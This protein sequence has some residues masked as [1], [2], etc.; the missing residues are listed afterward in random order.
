MKKLFY[1]LALLFIASCSDDVIDNPGLN[2]ESK[3][4]IASSHK[5]SEQ[6]AI[7]TIMAHFASLQND[8]RS[9]GESVSIPTVQDVEVMRSRDF[10]IDSI[11][12]QDLYDTVDTMYQNFEANDKVYLD[13][14]FYI[15]NFKDKK[16][17]AVLAADDRTNPIYAIV[18]EGNYY[19]NS[20]STEQNEG[21]LYFFDNSINTAL[22]DVSKSLKF[23]GVHRYSWQTIPDDMDCD[24]MGYSVDSV[25]RF[26]PV[27]VTRWG[28][29]Y[30]YNKYCNNCATGCVITATAQILSH[31]QTIEHVSW[32]KNNQHGESD[33]NWSRIL[34]DV[35]L[36]GGP[37]TGHSHDATSTE[38]VAHLMR[39]LGISMDAK[40]GDQTSASQDKAIS[41]MN[42]SGGLNASNMKNFS[43]YDVVRALNNGNLIFTSGY[44]KKKKFL[45]ITK[46][47]KGHA[48]VIDGYTIQFCNKSDDR[49]L[50]H[51]NWGW[52]GT[53]NG[54]YLSNV[55]DTSKNED[56]D[57]NS[58]EL[59]N[60]YNFKYKQQY[61]IVSRR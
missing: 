27:L 61:S 44:A 37:L 55:F 26:A 38:E 53:A 30:P 17:W 28:Q 22:K 8:A 31:F 5:V 60:N 3:S 36:N 29:G 24:F 13:T 58:G 39:Y 20:L 47:T 11:R 33:L 50:F 49:V 56:P 6:Q 45:F 46:Y 40:Y 21:L 23:P 18:D 41:W 54:Y 52:D 34:R 15:V 4:Y 32:Q 57:P 16:G 14:L 12:C 25:K 19:I 2:I 1:L 35:K 9:R 7:N 59:D 48:W 42:N 51:C 43:K 10:G